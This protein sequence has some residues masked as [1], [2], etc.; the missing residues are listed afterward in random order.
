MINAEGRLAL[1]LEDAIEGFDF[2]LDAASVDFEV[3]TS[4]NTNQYIIVYA[5]GERHAYVTAETF[6]H[7]VPVVFVDIC[8]VDADGDERWVCGDMTVAEAIPYIVNA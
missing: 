1:A 8:S 7:G 6:A 4:P 5:D 3:E 2:S